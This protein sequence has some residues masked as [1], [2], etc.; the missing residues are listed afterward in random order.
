VKPGAPEPEPPEPKPTEDP[1]PGY[2]WVWRKPTIMHRGGKEFLRRGSWVRH[3]TAASIPGESAYSDEDPGYA[4]QTEVHG[5]LVPP[6]R[7]DTPAEKV[8]SLRGA[9]LA[10]EDLETA[11]THLHQL[12]N[13]FNI[14]TARAKAAGLPTAEK[15][16]KIE[17]KW[18]GTTVAFGQAYQAYSDKWGR[19]PS[20]AAPLKLMRV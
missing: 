18:P 3:K 11:K 10:A 8:M 1:G 9:I 12:I 19:A 6:L 14:L 17:K 7:G 16:R 2:E 20:E 5:E 15:M 4:A 13:Y